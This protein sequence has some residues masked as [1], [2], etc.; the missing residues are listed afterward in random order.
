MPV[1]HLLGAF[2]PGDPNLVRVDDHDVVPGVDV[3][4]VFGFM[5]ASQ[6]VRYLSGESTQDLVG[7]I[8]DVPI[9]VGVLGSYRDRL[10]WVRSC[11]RKKDEK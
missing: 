6:S 5:L 3:R 9:M 4:R 7:C 2:V 10:H 11:Q 1:P 8:N